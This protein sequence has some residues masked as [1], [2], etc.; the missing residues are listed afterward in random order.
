MSLKDTLTEAMKTAMR[1][2][3]KFELGVIRMALSEIKRVEVDER[4]E[5]DDAR[6]LQILDK[7]TKQRRDAAAQFSAGGRQD[8]ADT[9]LAEVDLL[10]QFLPQPLTDSEVDALISEAILATGAQGPQGM[11]LVMGYVKP[12]AQGRADMQVISQRVKNALAP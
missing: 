3:A 5:L 10:K 9:E 6:I 12:K 8:L 1:S 2:H 7:M 11:G 4:I